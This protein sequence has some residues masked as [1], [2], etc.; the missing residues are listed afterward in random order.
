MSNR[1]RLLAGPR[2]AWSP[3]RLTRSVYRGDW[4]ADDYV[5]MTD[6]GSGVISAWTDG[7]AGISPT[8]AT[9]ARPTWSATSWLGLDGIERA[10]VTFN[11]S[12]SMTATSTGSLP[13]GAEAG[14]IYVIAS[15]VSPN[16]QRYFGYGRTDAQ[17]RRVG[18]TGS[19]LRLQ[20]DNALTGQVAQVTDP[21][22]VAYGP[23]IARGYWSGTTVGI[24][25]NGGDMVFNTEIT[26][27]DTPTDRLRLGS[28]I[29]PTAAQSL[30]GILRRVIVTTPLSEANRYRMEGYL[31]WDSGLQSLLPSGHPYRNAAP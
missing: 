29:G 28:S 10:G 21:V 27:L 13:A 25:A 1:L 12:N 8:A 11:G 15:T 31:A 20:A 24:A 14:E 5:R 3:H 22:N 16:Q 23:V 30:V 18:M 4:N 9:T 6:D 19:T 7:I 2:A 26:A 17:G